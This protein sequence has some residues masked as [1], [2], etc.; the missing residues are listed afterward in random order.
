MSIGE[1]FLKVRHNG[2]GTDAPCIETEQKASDTGEERTPDVV[3]DFESIE[4]R[5]DPNIAFD[6]ERVADSREST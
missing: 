1:S 6:P 2:Y 4:N 5:V 3:W